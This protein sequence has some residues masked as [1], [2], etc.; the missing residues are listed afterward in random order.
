MH[1]GSHVLTITYEKPLESYSQNPQFGHYFLVPT[2][3]R[4]LENISPGC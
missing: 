1:R 3:R 4:L 2:S